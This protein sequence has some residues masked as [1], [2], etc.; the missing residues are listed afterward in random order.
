M[1]ERESQHLLL[2]EA[3]S[4]GALDPGTADSGLPP[5][6]GAAASTATGRPAIRGRS[7]TPKRAPRAAL[8]DGTRHRG[9]YGRKGT[10][11]SQRRLCGRPRFTE[12]N[13]QKKKHFFFSMTPDD[14]LE[15]DLATHTERTPEWNEAHRFPGTYSEDL[16]PGA[17]QNF[18]RGVYE[19]SLTNRRRE[20]GTKPPDNSD[21]CHRPP[22]PAWAP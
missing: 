13:V 5:T 21:T 9:L 6:P 14:Q 12:E 15:P 16:A 4:S 1:S 18:H 20:Q 11:G 22:G 3:I 17:F 7:G 19:T 10:A 2:G 8:L